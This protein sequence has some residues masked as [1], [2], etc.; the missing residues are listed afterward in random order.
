MDGQDYEEGNIRFGLI[1]MKLEIILKDRALLN[2]YI[3][4]SC[5]EDTMQ[6]LKNSVQEVQETVRVLDDKGNDMLFPNLI[7]IN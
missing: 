6:Q 4:S 3:Y 2:K 7:R 5:N 1:S